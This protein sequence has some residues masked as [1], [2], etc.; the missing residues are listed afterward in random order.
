MSGLNSTPSARAAPRGGDDVPPVAGAEIDDV[1]LRRDL[2]HVQH[3]L[4]QRRRCGHPHHV[5]AGLAH[6]W[7]EL[8]GC[9]LGVSRPH[10]DRHERDRQ[11]H[12][13]H[14]SLQIHV[15]SPV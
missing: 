8:A 4:D 7:L 9:D 14:G 5:L 15:R 12:S 6:L 10:G 13:N 11:R 3:P 1:I 2:R